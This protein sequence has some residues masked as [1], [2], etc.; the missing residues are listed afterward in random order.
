MLTEENKVILRRGFEEGINE[1]NDATFDE[2]ISPTYVNHDM[3]APVPGAEGFKQMIGMFRAA[4]PD[5]RVE[6]EDVLGE[7]DRVATRGTMIGTQR[8]DF[9]GVPPTGQ[10][11]RVPYID[12]W[13]VEGG[14]AGENW[15]QMDMMG[16]MQQLGVVPWPE[17]ARA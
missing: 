8:G 7:G 13:R 6:I 16:M 5:L 12:I 14:K 3:P 9:M 4:F 1:G 17:Q 2:T 15:V 11:V 10:A